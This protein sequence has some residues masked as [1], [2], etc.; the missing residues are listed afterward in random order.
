VSEALTIWLILL[1]DYGRIRVCN[2]TL[3]IRDVR[4]GF[5]MAGPGGS[6]FGKPC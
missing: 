1:G 3:S 5:Q 2:G 4:V 6:R